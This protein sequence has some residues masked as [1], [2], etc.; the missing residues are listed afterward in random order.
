MLPV[1][2]AGR[3]FRRITQKVA[4]GKQWALGQRGWKVAGF[5]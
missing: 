2:P 3:K 4:K 1:L 5:F